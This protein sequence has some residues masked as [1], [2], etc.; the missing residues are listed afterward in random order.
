L[1]RAAVL[2]H[3]AF[4]RQDLSTAHRQILARLARVIVASQ[5]TVRPVKTVVLVGHTDNAG[6]AAYN[7]G[8]GLRR[9][10][11]VRL[12]LRQALA[13]LSPSLSRALRIVTR[14][15]GESRPVTSNATPAGRARNRRVVVYFSG[16]LLTR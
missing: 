2:D 7:Q 10:R 12:G 5:R 15:R 8:L 13:R 3:F 9:A 4:D 1:R 6:Q 14:S 16:R 11:A